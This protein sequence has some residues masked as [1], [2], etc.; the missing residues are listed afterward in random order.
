MN[1]EQQNV[2]DPTFLFRFVR[3]NVEDVNVPFGGRCR[4]VGTTLFVACRSGAS[5]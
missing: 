1:D 4:G 3:G 5:T 2:N